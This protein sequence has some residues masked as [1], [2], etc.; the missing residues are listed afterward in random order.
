MEMTNVRSVLEQRLSDALAAP[1]EAATLRD[2]RIPAIPGKAVAV[3]GVRRAGKTTF[4]RQQLARR[5][6]AGAPREGLL[7]LG[8]EDDRL[9]GMGTA[10]LDWVVEEY[11]RRH[12]RLR[13]TGQVTLCLDEIQ[14]VPG[15]ERFV[16]RLLDTERMELLLSGS[17]AKLLSREVATSLRGRGIEV[18]V[19]P[20]S[21][22]EVLRHSGHEPVRAWGEWD[23]ASRSSMDA[24]LRDYLET[25]GFPEAQGLETRDRLV[26]LRGYV[27]VM[28]LR[29]VIERHAVSNPTALLWLQRHL[30]SSPGG[31]FSVNR[32]FGA[33]QSQGVRVGKDTLHEYLDHLTDAFLVRTLWMHSASDRQRTVN[34]RKVYPV[35]PGLIPLYERSGRAHRGQALETAVLLELERRSWTVEYLRTPGGEVDFFATRPGSDPLVIQV[36]A[37]TSSPDTLGRELRGLAEGLAAH[38]SAEGILVT[39][40]HAPPR[41]ALPRRARWAPASGWLLEEEQDA[42]VV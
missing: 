12:P 24:R 41:L 22:R 21:F 27:D 11:F 38:P 5:L 29:D 2:I 17:S 1:L 13:G 6:K 42:S 8:L 16:R 19:H 20:F 37:D 3:I 39:M 4:L 33:L 30:L 31:A 36:A 23:A 9:V 7:L 34:P 15:W 14:V 25:G 32:V 35:D 26:L 28:T 10:E 18:L 40:D